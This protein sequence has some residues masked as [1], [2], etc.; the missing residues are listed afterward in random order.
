MKF[1]QQQQEQKNAMEKQQLAHQQQLNQLQN[2]MFSNPN[3][4]KERRQSAETKPK[5]LT[6]HHF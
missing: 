1:Q 5:F 6:R 3:A 4:N 2:G